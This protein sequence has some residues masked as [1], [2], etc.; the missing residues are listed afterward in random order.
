MRGSGMS[1]THTS[2]RRFDGPTEP[3]TAKSSNS[4]L[5]SLY[6]TP[7]AQELPPHSLKLGVTAWSVASKITNTLE[8]PADLCEIAFIRFFRCSRDVAA[9]AI[10]VGPTSHGAIRPGIESGSKA[11]GATSR[12][13]R[14]ARGA[15]LARHRSFAS[16]AVPSR[17]TPSSNSIDD[18]MVCRRCVFFRRQERECIWKHA[19]ACNRDVAICPSHRSPATRTTPA[20]HPRPRRRRRLRTASGR[21]WL[22]WKSGRPRWQDGGRRGRRTRC[23]ASRGGRGRRGGSRGRR[24]CGR[25]SR[26]PQ[27]RW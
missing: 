20:G 22:G 9:D 8:L 24:G 23:S 17:R 15:I 6:V 18:S 5:G 14:A 1:K 11:A 3:L 21:N 4:S 16:C 13:S 26:Y 12:F 25:G 19:Y 7:T 27:R 10:T 2:C